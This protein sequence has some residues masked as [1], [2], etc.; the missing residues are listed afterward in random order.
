MVVFVAVLAAASAQGGGSLD[1]PILGLLGFLTVAAAIAV[2][3][4]RWHGLTRRCPLCLQWWAREP[5]GSKELDRRRAMKTVTRAD[6]YSG[7][8]HRSDGK[9]AHTSGTFWRKEQI[10]VERVTNEDYW[11]CKYCDE[12]WTTIRVEDRENFDL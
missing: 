6:S 10:M 7:S 12:E 5:L 4:T 3:G 1:N 2:G 9:S 11:R 8:T